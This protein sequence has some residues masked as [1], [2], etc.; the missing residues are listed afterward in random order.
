MIYRATQSYHQCNDPDYLLCTQ[1]LWNLSTLIILDQ[2]FILVLGA[3]SPSNTCV[4]VNLLRPMVYKWNKNKALSVY[5]FD[6]DAHVSVSVSWCEQAIWYFTINFQPRQWNIYLNIFEV[7]NGPLL[8]MNEQKH[9]QR[10]IIIFLLL[11]S[12]YCFQCN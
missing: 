4:L 7:T 8:V 1:S 3:Q 9:I 5:N 10:F 2:Y 6:F 12:L 11:Y